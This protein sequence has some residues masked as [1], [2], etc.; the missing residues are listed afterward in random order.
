MESVTPLEA[1]A[2]LLIKEPFKGNE[3]YG[4]LYN[5]YRAD[6]TCIVENGIAKARSVSRII[7]SIGQREWP[8]TLKERLDTV[9]PL[10]LRLAVGAEISKS[11]RLNI[12]KLQKLSSAGARADAMDRL[13]ANLDSAVLEVGE[14][15][16]FFWW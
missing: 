8:S 2:T 10:T 14:K 6:G 9:D 1:H 11:F 16:T 13:R 7:D 4:V 5:L 15:Q 3:E 12:D